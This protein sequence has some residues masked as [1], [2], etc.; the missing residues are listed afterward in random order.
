MLS[1]R[2]PV[3][4][5]EKF[6]REWF[7]KP[8]ATLGERGMYNVES[9]LRHHGRRITKRFDPF[10]YLLYSRAMDLHDVSAGR[11]GMVEAL[12][13]VRCRVLVVGIS[14]DALYAASEVHQG[15]DIL[16]H[17]GRDVRYEEIRSP[18]G[19]DAF[20]LETDQLGAMLHEAA[21]TRGIA[22]P[23]VIE[24]ERRRVGIGILG[25]GKVA[26]SF[27]RLLGERR[28][29][30]R[31]RHGLDLE[32]RAVAEIDRG[33]TLDPAFG[34]LEVGFDPAALVAR[35]DLDVVLDLTRGPGA[36]DLVARALTLRRH[37]VTPNKTL[38]R[39]AGAELERIAFGHGVRLAYHDAIAGGWPLVHALERPLTGRQM[40]DLTAMVSSACNLVLERLEAG[41]D[42]PEAV[43]EA[44]ERGLSEPD[45][46]LDLSGWDTAEKLGLLLTR[47]TGVR[48]PGQHVETR[49]IEDLDP[50]LVR[51]APG[52]GLRIKLVGYADEIFAAPRAMV[53]PLAVP[54]ESHLGLVRGSDNVVVSH[55][56]D[57]EEMVHLGSGGGALPVATAVLNDIL[58]LFDP[59]HSWTGRFPAALEPLAAPPFAEWLVRDRGELSRRERPEP[60][61]VPC[62][63]ATPLS[64][65]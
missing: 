7:K 41:V 10:T 43:R 2:T 64:N 33:K 3:G 52:Q 55:T 11:G 45:P 23:T 51:L 15:A 42:L 4:L 47:M 30:L 60:G 39:A 1:Y 35:Q 20:L 29:G 27:V 5:E 38:L 63:P 26:A 54:A 53:G 21:R 59:G 12:D 31:I 58:G 18:H 65:F 44:R 19:H 22:V 16:N 24:R 37:V 57:G 6:G 46:A 50:A 62:L 56:R 36:R 49:G 32:I 34:G 25:A 28:E 9:W 13:R 8:G 17:Q 14:S 48:H 61:A 40:H